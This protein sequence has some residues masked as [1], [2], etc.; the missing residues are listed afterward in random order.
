MPSWR[1][2]PGK[3]IC[4]V[5]NLPSL[6]SSKANSK[7]TTLPLY[8][9]YSS[10]TYPRGT[11]STLVCPKCQKISITFDPFMY[12]SLP[13]PAA[14]SKVSLLPSFLLEGRGKRERGT[15]KVKDK[16]RSQSLIH[17]ADN[18]CVL[19]ERE[20]YHAVR[21]EGTTWGDGRN[22][23]TAAFSPRPPSPSS[24]HLHASSNA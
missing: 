23:C 7:G 4:A 2:S 8:D 20:G 15:N 5:T 24:H 10:L 19:Y 21:T 11:C 9:F 6:T 16:H 17:V 22:H 18:I 13:M 14:K 12:I 1:K 3:T